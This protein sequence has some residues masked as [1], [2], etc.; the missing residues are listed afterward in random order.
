M[1]RRLQQEYDAELAQH[2]GA[3]PGAG[4]AAPSSSEATPV[5]AAGAGAGPFGPAPSLPS[6]PILSYYPDIDYAQRHDSG[7]I[8]TTPGTAGGAGTTRRARRAHARHRAHQR[9][10]HVGHYRGPV[11][12]EKRCVA[13]EAAGL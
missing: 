11:V 5:S 3:N 9:L 4:G 10:A 8:P 2:M 13:A 7:S 6:N 12:V 1:A